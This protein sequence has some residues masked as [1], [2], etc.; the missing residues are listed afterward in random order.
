M[1]LKVTQEP[2]S[3]R[4]YEADPLTGVQS[5]SQAQWMSSAISVTGT[6]TT[7][8][9]QFNGTLTLADEKY[10]NLTATLA[11]AR[12]A[13]SNQTRDSVCTAEPGCAWTASCRGGMCLEAD[14]R[15]P[16]TCPASD[17]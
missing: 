10:G 7:S 1:V 3:L 8:G 15:C 2:N 5:G 11:L 4:F 13:C 14:E 16:V 9:R 12:P 17:N 6:L